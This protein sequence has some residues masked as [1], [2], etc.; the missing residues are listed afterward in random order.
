MSR[1]KSIIVI[2]GRVEVFAADGKPVRDP[3]LLDR[4]DGLVEPG[5]PIADHLDERLADADLSGGDLRLVFE[6]T[7]GVLKAVTT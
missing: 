1:A 4:L 7:L 3:A 5:D 2:S 6:P